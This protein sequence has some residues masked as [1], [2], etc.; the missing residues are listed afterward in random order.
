[1][2]IVLQ[3]LFVFNLLLFA[4]SSWFTWGAK[5]RGADSAIQSQGAV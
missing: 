5:G 4:V 1:M 2:T 3:T